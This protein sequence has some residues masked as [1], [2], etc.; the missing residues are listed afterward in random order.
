MTPGSRHPTYRLAN[1]RVSL[2]PVASGGEIGR[3]LAIAWAALAAWRDTAE[4][5]H[6][7]TVL[8]PF[9]IPEAGI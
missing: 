5:A 2:P 9:V 7:I 6:R 4:V 8:R 1:Y 3:D